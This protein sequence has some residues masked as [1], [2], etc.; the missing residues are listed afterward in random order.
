MW[1]AESVFLLL[2]GGQVVN[3][4]GTWMFVTKGLLHIF[5]VFNHFFWV[6]LSLLVPL[7]RPVS[8]W[9][10]GWSPPL[11][12]TYS[13]KDRPRW[14]RP[15]GGLFIWTSWC[16]SVQVETRRYSQGNYWYQTEVVLDTAHNCWRGLTIVWRY[17]FTRANT[18]NWCWY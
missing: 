8:S 12:T 13:R 9:R 15:K 14:P 2:H 5:R 7:V 3:Q 17:L 1:S 4:F 18:N 11:S 10:M 6:C 16:I